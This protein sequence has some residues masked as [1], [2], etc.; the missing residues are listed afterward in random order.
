[1]SRPNAA[2]R[3]VSSS[4]SW[5]GEYIAILPPRHSSQP[6]SLAQPRH[7][8]HNTTHPNLNLFH[9][10]QRKK[11]TTTRYNNNVRL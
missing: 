11:K 4:A 10:L 3:H 9:Q 8:H 1:M 2:L 7:D 6:R 5:R